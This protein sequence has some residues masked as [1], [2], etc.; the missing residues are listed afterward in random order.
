MSIS[1]TIPKYDPAIDKLKHQ[2]DVILD[3]RKETVQTVIQDLD[4]AKAVLEVV[5]KKN[6]VK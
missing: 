5:K 2:L 1:C 6:G 4:K 3:K